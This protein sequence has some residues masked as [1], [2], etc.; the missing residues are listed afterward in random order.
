MHGQFRR[1]G[2]GLGEVR[3]V[4]VVSMSGNRDS[5]ATSIEIARSSGALVA[6]QVTRRT[7]LRGQQAEHLANG[8]LIQINALPNGRLYERG[9]RIAQAHAKEIAMAELHARM[10]AIVDDDRAVRDSLQFLLEVIG[11]E[12]TTF[13]SAEAFLTAD[14]QHV[15]RL[16]LDHHMPEMNGLQLAEKLR[17]DGSGVPILLFTG[18]PS[19]EI[20]ARASGLG[21]RVLEKPPGEEDILGFINGI[22]S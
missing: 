6:P 18:S 5:L 19:P 21:I 13:A 11:Y 2:I 4:T 17:A 22:R 15:D 12:V 8:R 9:G 1:P 20:V 7:P 14:L 16:I 3:R 10:I